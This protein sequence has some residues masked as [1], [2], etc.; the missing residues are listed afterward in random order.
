MERFSGAFVLALIMFAASTAQ[1]NAA[2]QSSVSPD[3]VETTPRVAE[4]P[5]VRHG[6]IALTSVSAVLRLDDR[7]QFLDGPSKRQVDQGAGGPNAQPFA[8]LGVIVPAVPEGEPANNRWA[9]TVTYRDTGKVPES[10]SEI[11][12]AGLLEQVKSASDRAPEVGAPTV[13]YLGWAQQPVYD[14]QAHT[15]ISAFDILRGQQGAPLLLYDIRKLGRRGVL[16][17][18]ILAPASA[19][20][21]VSTAAR[22]LSARVGFVPG[23]RY[24]DFQPG[25]RL[26]DVHP[27]DLI[28]IDNGVTPFTRPGTAMELIGGG[29]VVLTLL[30]LGGF[31]VVSALRA[32]RRRKP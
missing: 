24:E 16:R 22:D 8:T 12:D 4:P 26:A 6:V 3:A 19:L 18:T 31:V 23:S 32:R 5:M 7:Y 30:T 9:A 1:G 15:L 28:L 29:A 21:E 25:D 17:V 20:A 10:L 2:V 13:R 11:D 14:K 27:D